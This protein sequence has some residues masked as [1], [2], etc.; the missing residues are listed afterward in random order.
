MND[1]KRIVLMICFLPS[2]ALA[3]SR[4]EDQGIMKPI[5]ALFKG[6]SLGDSTMVRLAFAQNA[7]MAT[8]GKD[9]S[10]KAAVGKESSIE[11]FVKAVGT[12]HN[13]SWNEPIWDISI[14]SDGDFAQVWASYAF[15]LGKT[16]KHCGVDSFQ[17]IKEE[18]GWKIFHLIDT[19]QK[20]GCVIPSSVSSQ[21]K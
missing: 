3:Q 4:T 8:I 14:H 19:R 10:G 13:E 21:F 5:N 2:L 15:Y 6:M 20:E 9:K 18:G 16:F 7:T 17:L 1:M 11:G 12:S